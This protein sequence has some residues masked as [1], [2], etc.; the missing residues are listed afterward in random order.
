MKVHEIYLALR[1]FRE[2][3]IGGPE[4]LVQP[5]TNPRV[6]VFGEVSLASPSEV[7]GGR[8]GPNL[9]VSP[10]RESDARHRHLEGH[11]SPSPQTPPSFSPASSSAHSL[12][13]RT[14]IAEGGSPRQRRNSLAGSKTHGGSKVAHGR[15]LR[16]RKLYLKMLSEMDWNKRDEEECRHL[17]TIMNCSH[18]L[19]ALPEEARA[20]IARLTVVILAEHGQRIFQRGDASDAC[21]LVLSGEVDVIIP[22]DEGDRNRDVR[23]SRVTP[24][25]SFG[26]LALVRPGPRVCDAVATLGPYPK[27][28]EPVLIAAISS[29]TYRTVRDAMMAQRIVRALSSSSE[30]R[31]P[32]ELELLNRAIIDH[33]PCLSNV[34]RHSRSSISVSCLLSQPYPHFPVSP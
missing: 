2:L 23:L 31:T 27:G 18:V 7:W 29:T 21:Y 12:T 15:G 11:S 28:K 9:G 24:G 30:D 22:D 13:R 4:L 1:K 16:D 33:C 5:L 8:A 25:H 19:R 34:A 32:E 3:G 6:L 10:R 14:S 20:A 17:A 26:D